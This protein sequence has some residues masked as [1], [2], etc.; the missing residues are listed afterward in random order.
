MRPAD[1][2]ILTALGM[3]L[4]R[5]QRLDDAVEALREVVR[6]APGSAPSH[7]NLGVVLGDKS[8][9]D[10]ALEEF[11]TALGIEPQSGQ[12][13]FQRGRALYEMRRYDESLEALTTARNVLGET[14][15]IL[16]YIGQAL[17][18]SA[19]YD[20]AANALR[21][22]I[23][24]RSDNH[25]S[26]AE[27]G[28][29]LLHVGQSTEAV[30]S[31]KR[32]LELNPRNSVATVTLIKALYREGS[33]ETAKYS[34]RLRDLK[35]RGEHRGASQ[36]T[37]KLCPGS[38]ESEEWGSAIEQLREAVAVCADC[39]IQATLRKNL[40]LVLADSGDFPSAVAE[41]RVARSLDDHPDIEYALDVVERAASSPEP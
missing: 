35:P 11:E 7:I 31:L 13:S 41:L 28:F 24:Q 3:T 1:T 8:Q 40:G 15:E 20:E 14:P 22:A 5:Q 29:A 17:N 16:Q 4:A 10:E 2:A 32:A 39:P 34:D 38:R 27:L 6:I 25:A 33:E 12:A 36:G 19:R 21:Q 26:H 30:T 23:L 37:L 18:R 9:W